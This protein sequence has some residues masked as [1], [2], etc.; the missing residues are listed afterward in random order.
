MVGRSV[1]KHPLVHVKLVGM[2]KQHQGFMKM[3]SIL[4]RCGNRI[5]D[6]MSD[7][8]S[9]SRIL[10]GRK[11]TWE[12]SWR[13]RRNRRRK[14]RIRNKD[15]LINWR[16]RWEKWKENYQKL[17]IRKKCQDQI[18]SC[19]TRLKWNKITE[20]LCKW[21]VHSIRPNYNLKIMRINWEW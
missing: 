12:L 1:R 18:F 21:V 13:I 4:R 14:L 20:K 3:G 9:T 2:G 10:I 19:N 11:G 16:K 8:R 5:W 6:K 17:K 15:W 7:E